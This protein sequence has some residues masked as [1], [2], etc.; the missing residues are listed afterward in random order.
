MNK[1]FLIVAREYITRVRKKS[2]ILMT[3]LGPV[4][5]AA[6]IIL[7]GRLTTLEDGELITIAVVEYDNYGRPVPDSLQF[8]RD[9]I[10]DKENMKFVYLNNMRLQDVLKTY[11]A[12]AYDGILF[13]GQQ[14]MSAGRE[15]YADFYYRK[16]PSLGLE[17]HISKA[18]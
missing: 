3:F 7:P 12:G 15:S 13:L 8:F 11:D 6:L 14:M 9:V 2:F 1:I 17:M 16:P 5:F 18:L 4:L 10:P